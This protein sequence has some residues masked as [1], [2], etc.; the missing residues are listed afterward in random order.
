MKAGNFCAKTCGNCDAPNFACGSSC[1]YGRCDI[2]C[3]ADD[4]NAR[5]SNIQG[6]VLVLDY[7][8]L[9][10]NAGANHPP[11]VA[12]PA[13][14]CDKCKTTQG[15]N[16]WVFCSNRNGCGSGCESYVNSLPESPVPI[17]DGNSIPVPFPNFGQFSGCWEDK[18]PWLMCSL[19]SI[20]DV[21]DPTEIPS[22]NEFVSGVIKTQAGCPEGIS[23]AVCN[24]C[25]SSS[26]VSFCEECTTSVSLNNQLFCAQCTDDISAKN[27]KSQCTDCLKAV[28]GF[29][30]GCGKCV[31]LND[32]RNA[33]QGR[34]EACFECTLGLKDA[35]S[36][37]G[38]YSCFNI[39]TPDI[40]LLK[41]C[42]NQCVKDDAVASFAKPECGNCYRNTFQ[43]DDPK[44][45]KQCLEEATEA[46]TQCEFC[47]NELCYT[48]LRNF[49]SNL[50]GRKG[51]ASCRYFDGEFSAACFD[52]VN[53][54]KVPDLHK[55]SCGQ[56]IYQYGPKNTATQRNACFGCLQQVAS[57]EASGACARCL[58]YADIDSPPTQC[59]DCVKTMSERGSNAG[60]CANCEELDSTEDRAACYECTMDPK[61]PVEVADQ[62]RWCFGFWAKEIAQ[63]QNTTTMSFGSQ[64]VSCLANAKTVDET[65]KCYIV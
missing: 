1:A 18:Y 10:Y 14:C 43:R 65:Q 12:N 22:S 57:E 5:E 36:Q 50:D 30:T 44:R 9:F 51:C 25:K 28:G 34:K 54:N 59:Y 52:C 42:S 3:A 15:C 35:E 8:S 29:K 26:D 41:S 53:D 39:F 49:A 58:I 27:L 19:K 38:C 56:C 64:C 4:C 32:Q 40:D 33:P 20:N 21:N 31:L 13:E 7:N 48:C 37:E 11:R 55:A 17:S 24:A 2:V 16:A 60:S 61:K 63:L 46:N 47:Y 45:C 6:Q 62:C 23:S